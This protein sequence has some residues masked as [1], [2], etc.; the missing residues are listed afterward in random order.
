EYHPPRWQSQDDRIAAQTARRVRPV[1]R[2][3]ARAQ[4]SDRGGPGR[5]VL[6]LE[7]KAIGAHAV[8]AGTVRDAG[9][10][11]P[12]CAEA[13]T[14][15]ARRDDWHDASSREFLSEQVPEAWLHR[16]RQWSPAEDQQLAVECRIARLT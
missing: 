13:F 15:N 2:A 14:G 3:H 8:A 9:Q 7:R 6:K 16:V 1:H 4:H 10:A 5:S 12:R 11:R